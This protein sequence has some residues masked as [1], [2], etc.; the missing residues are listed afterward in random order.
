VAGVL[1]ATATPWRLSASSG[2]WTTL[3]GP[4]QF[5]PTR[6]HSQKGGGSAHEPEHQF[7]KWRPRTRIQLLFL[8]LAMI[9]A[10]L[11]ALISEAGPFKNALTAAPGS[12][13]K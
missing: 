11:T 7:K 4:P 13:K 9:L 12:Q 8:F 5:A 6:D 3:V 10:L 2:A 1:V